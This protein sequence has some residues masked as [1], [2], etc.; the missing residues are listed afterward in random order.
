MTNRTQSR[1]WIVQGAAV[2]SGAL[3]RYIADDPEVKQ[4]RQIASD[5]VVLD[6]PADRARRLGS[7]VPDLIIEADAELER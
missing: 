1:R 4:L 6:M 5:V 2:S 7:E 3:A